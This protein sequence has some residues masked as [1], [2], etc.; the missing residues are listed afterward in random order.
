M[1]FSLP[2]VINRPFV[3]YHACTMVFVIIFFTLEES[4]LGQLCFKF[5]QNKKISVSF[6]FLGSKLDQVWFFLLYWRTERTVNGDERM[7]FRL[8]GLGW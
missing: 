8:L 1:M 5:F 6:F 4:F 2:T 7:G 3:N